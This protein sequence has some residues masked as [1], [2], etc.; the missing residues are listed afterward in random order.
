VLHN[1]PSITIDFAT[2]NAAAKKL[3]HVRILLNA[4]A[5]EGGRGWSAGEN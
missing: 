3:T 5:S 1:K 2:G 4:D